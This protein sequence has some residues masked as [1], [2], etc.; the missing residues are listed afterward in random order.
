[1]PNPVPWTLF[2]VSLLRLLTLCSIPGCLLRAG[3]PHSAQFRVGPGG[4]YH[5]CRGTLSCFHM[6]ALP[7]RMTDFRVDPMYP[8][9][10]LLAVPVCGAR[11]G[12]VGGQPLPARYLPI[13]PSASIAA[14]I[15]RSCVVLG[16]VVV[17]CAQS[18][19]SGRRST[20]SGALFVLLRPRALC[21]WHASTGSRSCCSRLFSQLPVSDRRVPVR[22]PEPAA[23]DRSRRHLPL[24]GE[25]AS[26]QLALSSIDLHFVLISCL[27]CRVCVA[28]VAGRCIWRCACSATRCSSR[29]SSGLRSSINFA[30]ALVPTG[31]ESP[32]VLSAARW[33]C[34]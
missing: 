3:V 28:V 31:A 6:T 8:G 13:S 10:Q 18:A 9:E 19:S 27:V 2:R 5:C 30:L 33:V 17:R 1:M 26:S 32:L 14:G 29:S 20:C 11:P 25:P 24:R 4:R 16:S 21:A 12:L 34:R 22:G 23:H 7:P 15:D